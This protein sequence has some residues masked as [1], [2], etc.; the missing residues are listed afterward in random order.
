M[1]GAAV[2]MVK[3]GAERKDGVESGLEWVGWQGGLRDLRWARYVRLRSHLCEVLVQHVIML[4]GVGGVGEEWRSGKS[5][6]M[7]GEREAG[8]VPGEGEASGTG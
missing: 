4:S 6:G 8:K 2:S 5:G 1:R 3:I 7:G